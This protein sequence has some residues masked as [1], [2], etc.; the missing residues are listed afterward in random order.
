M[1][2]GMKTT[3]LKTSPRELVLSQKDL[4]KLDLEIESL[5]FGRHHVCWVIKRPQIHDVSPDS[6]GSDWTFLLS[7]DPDLHPVPSTILSHT[8]YIRFSRWVLEASMFRDK[9]QEMA[10]VL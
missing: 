1:H 2:P 3:A 10:N 4:T 8:S 9:C 6:E 5:L 7:D